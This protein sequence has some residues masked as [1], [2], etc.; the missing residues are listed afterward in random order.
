MSSKTT[1]S[2][3]K[4]VAI[5]AFAVKSDEDAKGKNK[6]NFQYINPNPH[7][8]VFMGVF[9]CSWLNNI[10]TKHSYG[11]H[12]FTKSYKGWSQDIGDVR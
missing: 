7:N 5:R 3:P 8:Q 10:G 4:P 12:Y 2:A 1:T 11:A 6:C 9:H